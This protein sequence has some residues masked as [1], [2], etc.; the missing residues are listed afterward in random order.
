MAT[1][2]GVSWGEGGFGEEVRGVVDRRG[3]AEG[4][5]GEA[6]REGQGQRDSE[7]TG[8]YMMMMEEEEE[9]G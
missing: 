5:G 9:E 2:R 1:R 4:E 7:V 8:R 6:C 3:G